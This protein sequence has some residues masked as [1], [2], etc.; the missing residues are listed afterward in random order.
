[1]CSLSK[2]L[3]NSFLSVWLQRDF[4]TARVITPDEFH[5]QINGLIEEFKR[6]TSNELVLLFKLMQVTNLAN[7]LATINSSNWE[8]IVNPIYNVSSYDYVG[9]GNPKIYQDQLYALTLPRTY[10]ENNCSCVLQSNCTRFSTFPYMVSNQLTNQTLPNFLTG[11]LPFDAMLQSN[12]S[13]FYNQTCLSL[14]HTLI[15]FAKPFPVKTLIPSSS[16][17]SNQTVETILAQLFVEKWT[18][19]VLFDLYYNE[20]APKLCQYSHSLPFNGLYFLTKT[21]SILGGM[22][23][24][25]LVDRKRKRKVAP[26][27]NIAETNSDDVTLNTIPNVPISAIEINVG[28]IQERRGPSNNRTDRIITICLCLLVIVA[29]VVASVI[30]TGKKDTKYI[31]ITTSVTTLITTTEIT[32]STTT[33]T[34]ICYMTLMYQSET[35][36]IGHDVK[37]F[38]LRDLNGDSFLDLAVVNYEDDTFSILLGNENGTFQPQQIYSTGNESYPWGIASG[39]FNNDTFL[40]IAVTL[41]KTNKI[42]IF[43]GHGSNGSFNRKPYTVLNTCSKNEEIR[44]LEVHDL[45]EDGCLDLL[46]NCYN[47][48]WN[49]DH[50]VAA[51]YRGDRCQDQYQVSNMIH[52][53]GID[54]VVVGDFDHNGK[55]NDI[56]FCSTTRNKVFIFSANNYEEGDKFKFKYLEYKIHGFPQSIIKGQ[57]NDDDFDDIALVSPQSDGL[58]VLLAKG[59]GEFLQQIYHINNSPTSVVRI[60]FN[61]DSIDDLAILNS[62]QTIIIYLGTKLGMFSE[63]KISF[64][65]G[66]NCTDQCFR[67]LKAADL[68][69]DGKDDLVFI[70]PTNQ[71]I[72][73]LLSANCNKHF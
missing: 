68:N 38:I 60:N 66:K 59:D 11:C 44:L 12:F 32:E 48:H 2:N 54:S 17:S 72:R 29:I 35:Y 22:I 69:R 39:H 20:S 55:Q 45:N 67:S 43:F 31:P 23:V 6:T 61:N 8:F 46:F 4:I 24:I 1:M 49:G 42:V 37:S 58:H 73:V 70:D 65:V 28:P 34:E 27:P 63:A 51:L 15:Y 30:S 19:N 13:C 14:L 64:Q 16:S 41:S 9:F 7:Q 56:G 10:N 21:L 5:V 3:L 40:D 50:F 18:Q 25:K 57:F 47:P 33:S 52:L 62:D 53:S 71:T 36:P 26:Y